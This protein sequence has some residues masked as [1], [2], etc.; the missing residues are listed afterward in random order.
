M[1]EK[2]CMKVE[3]CRLIPVIHI[4][5]NMLSIYYVSCHVF[6]VNFAVVLFI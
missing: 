2:D 5:L 1:Q 3:D 6:Y 4:C